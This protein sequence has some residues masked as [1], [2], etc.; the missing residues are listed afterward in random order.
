MGGVGSGGMGAINNYVP[1]SNLPG[2]FSEYI[3]GK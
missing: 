2:V 1:T 3:G